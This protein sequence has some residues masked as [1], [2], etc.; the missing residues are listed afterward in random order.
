MRPSIYNNKVQLNHVI[1][2]LCSSKATLLR[3]EYVATSKVEEPE[4]WSEP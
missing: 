4:G 2:L 1:I 3:N